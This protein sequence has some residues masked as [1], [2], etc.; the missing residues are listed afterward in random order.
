MDRKSLED[1]IKQIVGKEKIYKKDLIKYA[2]KYHYL[3]LNQRL[4]KEKMLDSIL[5]KIKQARP[6]P[7]LP[8][9]LPSPLPLPPPTLAP[10]KI[11][12]YLPDDGRLPLDYGPSAIGSH[13]GWRDPID[14]T[15]IYDS[16]VK[17]LPPQPLSNPSELMMLRASADA[18]GYGAGTGAGAS[19]DADLMAG[20]MAAEYKEIEREIER[21]EK[22]KAAEGGKARRIF[23]HEFGTPWTTSFSYR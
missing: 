16:L 7:P 23:L 2:Y 11:Y 1:H 19:A 15:I 13:V 18:A 6:R 3:E 12:G 20:F 22:E 4:T 9:S 8:L 21:I 10:P 5:E 17:N 14:N